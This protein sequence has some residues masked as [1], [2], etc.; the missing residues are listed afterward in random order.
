MLKLVCATD[1]LPKSE[2]ALERAGQL[3][4][5]LDAELLAL[6]VV[7]ASES[8]VVLEESLQ[9]AIGEMNARTRRPLWKPAREPE[10]LVSAGSPPRLIVQ[11]AQDVGAG[12]LVLGPHAGRGVR[13][14]LEGTIASKVLASRVCPVLIVSRPPDRR[15]RRVML[16]LDDSSA[17]VAAIRA[18]E[19]LVITDYIDAMVVNAFE[20][21]YRGVLESAGTSARAIE[22]YASGWL[23]DAAI[24]MRDLLKHHSSRLPPVRHLC[25]GGA[26]GARHS[27]SCVGSSA[28]FAGAWDGSAAVICTGLSWA[29]SRMR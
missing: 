22:Q 2:P 3:A 16:A 29:A 7:A 20:T 14:A 15:Y 18:A 6:H 8:S 25:G 21:P 4:E 28:G 26:S 23:T 24:R 1:L 13:D 11:T 27:A 10:V 12:L 19:D 9:V 17:S 5:S